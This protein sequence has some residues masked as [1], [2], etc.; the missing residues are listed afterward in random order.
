MYH[1]MLSVHYKQLQSQGMDLLDAMDVA[2]PETDKAK[3]PL[4]LP[5]ACD[6][7]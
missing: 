5:I 1:T 2:V 6:L 3:N 7:T 4:T